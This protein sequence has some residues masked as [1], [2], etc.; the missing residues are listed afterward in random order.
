M[1]PPDPARY[2]AQAA[3]AIGAAFEDLDEGRGYLY[4][5]SR[6]DRFILGGGGGV[7]AYPIN[8]APAFTIARDKA[9]TKSVL[10]HAGIPAIP[11]G[12][13]FAHQRRA[14]MRDPGRDIEDAIRYAERLG[15]PVFCKPNQGGRGNFAE[16]VPSPQ[17]LS[18]Y[19]LRVAIEFESF[20]VEPVITGIEHR[21][22]VMDERPLA[23]I[24]KTAPTLTGDG[25]HTWDELLNAAN[26]A[27]AG[28]GVSA[29]PQST[30]TA[31]GVAPSAVPAA[32]ES[33]VLAGR[34]NLHAAGNVETV[35]DTAPLELARLAAAATRALGLRLGAVDIFDA[36]PKRD[37]SKLLIIEVNG[38][39]G[40]ASL[41]RAGRADIISSLWQAMLTECLED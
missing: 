7:C 13:F 38:N 9:H 25:R 36:S 11:G 24:V 4:R 16:C 17:A 31:S 39:P 10:S 14:N 28:S 22:L 1:T 35:S 18:D 2:A 21:V 32:G 40:L 41:E 12:L 33:I 34:Q 30:L 20:L 19:A 3:A 15:F 37:L 6:N 23:H 5:V 27:L 8:A 29:A 26:E